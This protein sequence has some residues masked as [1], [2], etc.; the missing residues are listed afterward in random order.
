MVDIL[1]VTDYPWD[2]YQKRN[3]AS[4]MGM[5][6]VKVRVTN[7]SNASAYFTIGQDIIME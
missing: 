4:E 1:L 7:A 6:F 3:S 5:W 2:N